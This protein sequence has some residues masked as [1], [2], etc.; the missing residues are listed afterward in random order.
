VWV[1][2]VKDK[3]NTISKISKEMEVK[4][5]SRQQCSPNV[6][7]IYKI[8]KYKYNYNRD[9]YEFSWSKRM[10]SFEECQEYIRLFKSATDKFS[11]IFGKCHRKEDMIRIDITTPNPYQPKGEA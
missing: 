5:K 1:L 6:T 10:G 2:P 9:R 3:V 11:D 8:K 7:V 4:M